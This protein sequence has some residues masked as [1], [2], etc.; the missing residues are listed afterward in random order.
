MWIAALAEPMEAQP[1]NPAPEAPELLYYAGHHAVVRRLEE[2]D[3][4]RAFAMPQ[5]LHMLQIC[6]PSIGLTA[7]SVDDYL[8]R[9]RFFRS[10]GQDYEL[11]MTVSRKQSDGTE[12]RLGYLIASGYDVVN[13]KVELAAGFYRGQ[14]TRA[15]VEAM[16]WVVN[17]CFYSL[18]LH[19]LIFYVVPSQ[20]ASLRLMERLGITPEAHLRDEIRLPDGSR[21][22]LLRFAL[23]EPQWRAAQARWAVLRELPRA[24]D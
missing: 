17:S 9:L 12:E 5:Y 23:F 2:H 7:A 8:A 15:A 4:R 22:D 19:K 13:Q 3:V 18:K 20:T 1:T 6:R 10:L 16:V 14:G 24:V 11:E 21:S